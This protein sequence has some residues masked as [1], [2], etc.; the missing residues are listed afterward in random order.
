MLES[1][2]S[3]AGTDIEANAALC[4]QLN[5]AW[6]ALQIQT[7]EPLLTFDLVSDVHLRDDDSSR[8]SNFIKGLQDIA[9][10]HPESDA[11]VSVGDNISFGSD[12]NSRGQ[13]FDLIEEY[14]PSVPNKIMVLGNHDVR[15]N[16]SSSSNGFSSNYDVA[17][18][19][20]MED[21]AVYRDDPESD[22]IYFDKWVNGY[23]FIALNTEEGLKDMISM[24]DEQLTWLEEKLSEGLD[25]SGNR[26]PGGADP[27]KPVFVVVH[28]ALNDTHQRANDYGGFGE[29]DAQ[30]KEILSRHPQAVVLS[31]HIHN[32][33][34]VATIMDREYG[35]LV[36]VPSYNENQFGVTDD[37]TGYQVDVYA[38]RI[39][40]RARN[41]MTGTWLPQYDVI[42]AAPSLAAVTAEASDLADSSDGSGYTSESWDAF[43]AALSSAENLM[44]LNNEGMRLEAFEAAVGLDTALGGLTANVDKAA[45]QTLYEELSTK[46]EADYTPSSWAA[47]KDALDKAKEVLDSADASQ[48]DVDNAVTALEA[49]ENALTERAD[50]T[51]LEALY[52]ESENIKNENYTEESWDAFQAA[53]KAAY[54]VL[55]DPEA[56]DKDVSDALQALTD[57]RAALK[58]QPEDP[59]DPEDP[60][61]PNDP[62]DSKDPS[63]P[64]NPSDPSDPANPGTPSGT[65]DNSAPSGADK[66]GSVPKTGDVTSALPALILLVCVSG[67]GAVTCLSRKKK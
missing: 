8:A 12:N 56:S 40:F 18:E 54:A 20:Y 41:Y 44:G 13:Y 30:V 29:Q 51:D 50:T 6:D 48:D 33:L 36:D 42:L 31:G 17:Y 53:L 10:N 55:N 67:A 52:H 47:F 39:H 43:T 19:A 57:A 63:D 24:S 16:D 26:I 49:A 21:N 64:S 9:E 32:G 35:T 15:K 62:D 34:G 65:D 14:I 5:E 37:G 58:I 46:A 2:K 1:V 59:E 22:K 45:L 4:A 3:Q 27:E 38:D 7:N 11:F 23:H 66:D 61:K 28:Q 25:E 60:D